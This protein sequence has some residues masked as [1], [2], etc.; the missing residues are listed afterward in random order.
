MLTLDYRFHFGKYSKP[1]A[2]TLRWVI[3]NDPEYV[4]WCIE[5]IDWFDIDVDADLELERCLA[6]IG[7][8]D[9]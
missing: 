2:K 1:H 7:Y 3:E 5:N 4:I 6:D 8:F 9:C